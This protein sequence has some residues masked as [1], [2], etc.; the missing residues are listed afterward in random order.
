VSDPTDEL[1][2]LGAATLGETGGTPLPPE[3]RAMWTGARAAGPAF[4][5]ACGTGDNLALHVAAAEA[6]AGSVLCAGFDAPAD[7]GYWGEVLTTGA[8]ARGLVG[9]VIDGGVRDADALERLA[10]PVF[11]RGL[12]LQGA[13]KLAAG[14]VGGTTDLGGVAVN[15]G[16]WIVG[17]RDG[18]VV[19]PGDR[20]DDV[21]DAGRRR[22]AKEE[23]MFA[24]LRRGSTTVD[25]LDLDTGPVTRPT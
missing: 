1:L 18:V 22:A 12:V 11:A 10:F 7:R 2:A 24:A 16:D 21:L 5:A 6:P 4:V 17:D 9:L 20:L 25:L 19:I 13:T 14:T 23:E 3:I 8:Q 15:T